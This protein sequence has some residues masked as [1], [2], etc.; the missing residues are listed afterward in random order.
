MRPTTPAPPRRTALAEGQLR[1]VHAAE[2]PRPAHLLRLIAT[3][4]DLRERHVGAV[5]P[6]AR[7]MRRLSA[8][9]AV[10]RSNSR[11]PKVVEPNS[12]GGRCGCRVRRSQVCPVRALTRLI[13]ARSRPNPAQFCP[14]WAYTCSIR[15]FFVFLFATLP[16]VRSHANHGGSISGP[17]RVHHVST[18]ARERTRATVALSHAIV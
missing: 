6:A 8:V 11:S 17:I 2:A 15:V 4:A 7:R 1:Q 18:M 13:G 12:L 9:R 14:D 10:R 5:N 3:A 16:R